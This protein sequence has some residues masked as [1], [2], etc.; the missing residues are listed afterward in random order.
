MRFIFSILLNILFQKQKKQ[1]IYVFLVKNLELDSNLYNLKENANKS[2][3]TYPN[4]S[5][6]YSWTLPLRWAQTRQQI[7]RNRP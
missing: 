7:L 1:D 3:E 5:R 6:L 4:P 2:F